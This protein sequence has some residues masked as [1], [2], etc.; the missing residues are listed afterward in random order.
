MKYILTSIFLL[1]GFVV[2]SQVLE[3][4][5]LNFKA[6]EF[7]DSLG[8]VYITL[9]ERSETS[10]FFVEIND[11]LKNSFVDSHPDLT[12]VPNQDSEELPSCVD[13]IDMFGGETVIIGNVFEI[14]TPHENVIGYS[15]FQINE[16]Q[17]V[18]IVEIKKVVVDEN[19]IIT[20][21]VFDTMVFVLDKYNGWYEV[22]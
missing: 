3:Y 20:K 7:L 2:K 21:Y 10:L 12:Y 14:P 6:Q 4:Q 17:M 11:E 1:V 15:D 18:R 19:G 16:N 13:F 22:N 8:I 9:D 5:R